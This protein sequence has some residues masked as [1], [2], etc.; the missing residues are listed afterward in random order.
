MISITRSGLAGVAFRNG[1]AIV[2][3]DRS[4]VVTEAEW[5]L[6]QPFARASLYRGH[7]SARHRLA[8]MR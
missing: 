1:V 8:L 5:C 7:H 4:D 6:V 3:R 2:A